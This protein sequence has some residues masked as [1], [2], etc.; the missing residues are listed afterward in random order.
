MREYL[1]CAGCMRPHDEGLSEI[2]S[3]GE[4]SVG[5]YQAT[6]VD[7]VCATC[8]EREDRKR[9]LEE[10]VTFRNAGHEI[11]RLKRQLKEARLRLEELEELVIELYEEKKERDAF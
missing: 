4:L 1:A 6:T 8:F 10:V 2:W 7:W 9:L 11:V 5:E 3:R